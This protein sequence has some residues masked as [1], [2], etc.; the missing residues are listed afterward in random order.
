MGLV[1]SFQLYL[2]L[3]G[4]LIAAVRALRHSAATRNARIIYL[5]LFANPSGSATTGVRSSWVHAAADAALRGALRDEGLNVEVVKG[6]PATW[7]RDAASP[8]GIHFLRRR[9]EQRS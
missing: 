2:E 4:E 5:G 6:L 3:I 7:P 1:P 8:D 9:S